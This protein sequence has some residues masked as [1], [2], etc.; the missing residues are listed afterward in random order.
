MS[1]ARWLQSRW[2]QPRLSLALCWL[3]PLWLLFSVLAA[4][5]RLAYRRGWQPAAKLPVP[6]VV[7]GNLIVG[8]AG[9][10]PLT[11]ALVQALRLQGWHPGIISRGYGAQ[12]AQPY[13]RPVT[14]DSPVSEC[15]DEPLLL[16]QRGQCPVWVNKNRVAAAQALLAEHPEVDVIV[17]DDGLQHYA[18]GR[19]VSLAVFDARGAGNGWQL[20]LGP[21]REPLSRL[22]EV[23]AVVFNGLPPPNQHLTDGPPPRFN[24]QLLPGRFY[25]LGDPLQH[26]AASA[27]RGQPLH[28]IAGIGH[29]ERFFQTLRQLGLDFTPHAFPDHHAYQ[30]SDFAFGEA[31]V[32]LMTEKD[33]VKCAGLIPGEA[34]VLP[35]EADIPPALTNLI[36]EKLR[37]HQ[38]T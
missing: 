7:V 35:V 22:A 15:G 6:V 19:Q 25:R 32:C 34:W 3:A 31:A 18:L 37:G 14:M 12:A 24:M 1:F 17:C 20:P 33:A 36:V 4:L 8:G 2:F 11:L 26:T 13:P 9:K 21:L 28:A 29:P 16:A 23:D 5:R 27:L 30:S 38:T 10:T